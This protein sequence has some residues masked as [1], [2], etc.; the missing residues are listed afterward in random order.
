MTFDESIKTVDEIIRQ[1]SAGDIP[2]EKAVELYK[3]GVEELKSC[4]DKLT[5]AQQEMLKLTEA[6]K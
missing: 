6:G 2:L 3:K 4:N 1:L 5:A